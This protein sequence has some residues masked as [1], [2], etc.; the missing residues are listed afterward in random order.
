MLHPVVLETPDTHAA[1][2]VL[3]AELGIVGV[4]QCKALFIS[5]QGWLAEKGAPTCAAGFAGCI[6]FM[7]KLEVVAC[8]LPPLRLVC[9]GPRFREQRPT[10]WCVQ[11]A[12]ESCR[13]PVGD[14][15]RF[16][17]RHALLRGQMRLS[18]SRAR[19]CLDRYRKR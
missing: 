14:L 16:E 10:P 18:A 9:L 19:P 13:A 6:G 11:D 3:G 1:C 5:T 8:P 4:D 15:L 2:R 7:R 17:H 12:G